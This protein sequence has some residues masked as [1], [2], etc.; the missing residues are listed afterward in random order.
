MLHGTTVPVR[1]AHGNPGRFGAGQGA[2][3]PPGDSLAFGD[4]RCRADSVALV[5]V[6]GP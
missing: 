5:C 2:P 4:F 1:S 3:L 6:S